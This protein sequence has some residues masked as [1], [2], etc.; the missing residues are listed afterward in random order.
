[1]KSKA[2]IQKIIDDDGILVDSLLDKFKD[3][4]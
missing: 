2:F 3:N 1:M 4:L